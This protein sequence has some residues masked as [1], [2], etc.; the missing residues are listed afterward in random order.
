[1]RA[2]PRIFALIA[3]ARSF[4]LEAEPR[5]FALIAKARTLMEGYM[6]RL[7]QTGQTTCYSVF[8]DGD[9][10]IG[11]GKSYTVETLGAYS[12][13]VNIEVAHYAA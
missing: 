9:L 7:L 10:E 5:T 12:G 1:M 13:N 4:A 11:I 8:D 6:G 2:E 3:K